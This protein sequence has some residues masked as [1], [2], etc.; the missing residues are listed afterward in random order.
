[1]FANPSGVVSPS[2][3]PRTNRQ[4]EA[5]TDQLY[6]SLLAALKPLPELG[7]QPF[8]PR[9]IPFPFSFASLIQLSANIRRKF[10]HTTMGQRS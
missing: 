7:N 10:G 4:R 8:Y 3:H 6:A 1:M 9:H 2:F 5:Q